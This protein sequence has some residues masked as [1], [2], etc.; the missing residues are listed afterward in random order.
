MNFWVKPLDEKILERDLLRACERIKRS[1]DYVTITQNRASLTLNVKDII[2]LEKIG[3]RTE[4]YTEDA[5]YTTNKTLS[6][7]TKELNRELFVRIY[8]SYVINLMYVK[9]ADK[10]AVWLYGAEQPLTIGKAYADSF[11]DAFIAFHERQVLGL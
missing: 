5:R 1:G 2:Y 7:F 11:R 4:I 6:E 8:Q 3:R 10:T 9:K